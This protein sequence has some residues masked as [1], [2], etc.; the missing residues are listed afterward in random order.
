[1]ALTPDIPF[2]WQ[3]RHWQQLQQ[4][5]EQGRLPHALLLS[6]A[7]GLGKSSFATALA[8]ALLCQ[9]PDE[10][11][12][13]CGRCRSC[14]L[15]AAG[16]HPDL[17]RVSPEEGSSQI[18][19]DAVR[20]LLHDGV[21]SVGE[22]RHRVFILEPAD[23]LGGPAANALLKTLEEPIDGIHL[24]LLSAHPEKLPIT[25]RSR[26]QQL[27][28]LPPPGEQAVAWL[29]HQGVPGKRAPGLLEISGGAPLAA[30]EIA[31][32]GADERYRRMAEEFMELAQGEGNRDPVE[33]AER[34]LKQV[35]PGL[36]QGY[37]IS[38]LLQVIRQQLDG[39]RDGA[40]VNGVQMPRNLP[41]LRSVYR[42]LDNLFEIQRNLNH[43]LNAQLILEKLLLDWYRIAR[44]AY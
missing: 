42:L 9:Q 12:R 35:E 15:N 41:N 23:A 27:R 26:C 8:Q 32:N 18:R 25:I 36:L 13:A 22:C 6:G 11:G 37:M 2:P 21:L 34:W 14:R 7:V 29:E 10:A 31:A 39:G 30:L 24:L 19:I 40:P 16:T 3:Q 44:G 4:A 28:F 5:R 17:H 33:L 1:M 20:K 38:W 43:N